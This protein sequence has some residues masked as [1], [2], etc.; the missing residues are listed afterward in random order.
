MELYE[1]AAYRGVPGNKSKTKT[2]FIFS[3]NDVVH[4]SFLEDIQNMLNSGIIPNIYPAEE[5]SRIRDEMKIPYKHYCHKMGQ[6]FLE[7]PEI[8]NEWFYDRIKDNMHLS[9][10]MS[11][12]GERFREYTRNFPALI[13]NTAIDWFMAWPEEALIEVA[14]KYIYRIDID[15]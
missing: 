11:P 7:Q 14:K 2:V 1:Q 5:L 8:M 15:D 6:P 3:D 10:C 12:I 9:I 13:N 4:E